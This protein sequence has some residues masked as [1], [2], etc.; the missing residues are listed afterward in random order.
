MYPSGEALCKRSILT[1]PI[2]KTSLG[3]FPLK[4]FKKR[5]EIMVND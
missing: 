3:S 1:Y 4:V 2:G 5:N